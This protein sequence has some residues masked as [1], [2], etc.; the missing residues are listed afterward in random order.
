MSG[1]K[2]PVFIR[3]NS[4]YIEVDLYNREGNVLY[5][6]AD[7]SEGVQSVEFFKT[8]SKDGT[9]VFVIREG[10]FANGEY[11]KLSISREDYF[12]ALSDE[13]HPLH[14]TC[15]A[16]YGL[17]T[18]E[19]DTFSVFRELFQVK[20]NETKKVTVLDPTSDGKKEF[21]IYFF[22]EN[23]S[24][25]LPKCLLEKA[26]DEEVLNFQLRESIKKALASRRSHDKSAIAEMMRRR[27]TIAANL[28]R[29]D[30]TLYEISG[31][32]D[33]DYILK[34]MRDSIDGLKKIKNDPR[35]FDVW[36]DEDGLM[37]IITMPGD[38]VLQETEPEVRFPIGMLSI[39]L[40]SSVFF[41]F[42]T[43]AS[44]MKI[45][46]HGDGSLCLGSYSTSYSE[47]LARKNY[48]GCWDIASLV[49]FNV[50][51]EDTVNAPYEWGEGLM[52]AYQVD[53]DLE[54]DNIEDADWEEVNKVLNST[55]RVKKIEAECSQYMKNNPPSSDRR[56]N[57]VT[58][59]IILSILNDIKNDGKPR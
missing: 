50:N 6:I 22:H 26:S 57:P 37:H 40:S 8:E 48:L 4:E 56:G 13:K 2:N 3:D 7:Q 31:I 9:D 20:T 34:E 27:R 43:K 47:A 16:F 24:I 21:E 28:H 10:S 54:S 29:L 17:E 39:K 19:S 14:F 44:S 52:G 41:K 51:M 5:Y 25:C 49:L 30:R 32:S 35:V 46:P 33:K 42:I 53:L 38:M 58:E 12:T 55:D 45:H 1:L 18:F 11:V 23:R 36:K 15:T 59:E